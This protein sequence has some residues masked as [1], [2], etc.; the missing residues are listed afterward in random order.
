MALDYIVTAFSFP[1]G[2]APKHIPVRTARVS[3]KRFGRRQ[4]IEPE[5]NWRLKP[6]PFGATLQ[7]ET[8]SPQSDQNSVCILERNTTTIQNGYGVIPR[9][10]KK[11]R[12]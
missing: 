1:P 4:H 6:P 7:K 8:P 2:L 11:T 5:P 10:N 9:K 3:A 12:P